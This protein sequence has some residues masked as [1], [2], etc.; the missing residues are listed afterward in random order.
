MAETLRAI[1]IKSIDKKEKDKN[2]LLFSIEE[3]KEWVTLKGVKNPNAKMKLAQSPFCF[4]EFVIE[5]GKLGKIVVG[6]E[7]IESFHEISEDVDKYF[8]GTAILEILDKMD[9]TSTQERARVFLL[10]IKALKNICFNN[11]KPLYILDKFLIEIL[12]IC[13]TPL[14]TEKCSN[15]GSKSFDKL[16]INYV[17][18]ELVCS[19]CKDIYCEEFSKTVFSAL[20]ILNNT[21]FEKLSTIK[22]AENSEKT[23]LNILVNNFKSRFDVY[24]KFLGILS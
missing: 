5:E 24:L 18:G 22:L 6:F 10:S 16:Y 4:G 3:G 7:A 12:N 13:G 11:I 21:E 14:Y 9:F 23:L 19:G 8:E 2:I 17:T 20:K 1:N 15:C